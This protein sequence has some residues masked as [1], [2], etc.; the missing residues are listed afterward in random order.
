[1]EKHEYEYSGHVLEFD[2]PVAQ[3]W[4]GTTH[5]VSPEK[6]KANLAYQFKRQ[7]GRVAET[8]ITLPGAIHRVD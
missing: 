2:R 7:T 6:A 1:M 4:H 5:A 8:K 3:N